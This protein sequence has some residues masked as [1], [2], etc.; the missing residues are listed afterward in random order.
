MIYHQYS[1]EKVADRGVQAA[2]LGAAEDI[3]QRIK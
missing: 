1:E 3:E 2:L